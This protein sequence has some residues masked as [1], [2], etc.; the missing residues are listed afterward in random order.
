MCR[1]ARW[2]ASAGELDGLTQSCL[3]QLGFV[4]Q[5]G[6]QELL[7]VMEANWRSCEDLAEVLDSHG[8]R[9]R[10]LLRDLQR[11]K[12]GN[13]CPNLLAGGLQTLA[14][15]DEL[16]NRLGRLRSVWPR[17]QQ[18]ISHAH[19][20]V[21][22][23]ETVRLTSALEEALRVRRACGVAIAKASASYVPLEDAVEQMRAKVEE[24]QRWRALSRNALGGLEPSVAARVAAVLWLR[25]S[26]ASEDWEHASQAIM[27]QR[28]HNWGCGQ[29]GCHYAYGDGPCGGAA[30]SRKIVCI[31]A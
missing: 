2:P 19:R 26:P 24:R 27:M 4:K 6:C 5:I 7:R 12:E 30:V 14:G 16:A 29:H 21:E 15:L 20:S 10:T 23:F 25:G 31:A 17:L 28:Q 18:A 1:E 9:L 11:F 22:R 8:M 3:Q 13:A